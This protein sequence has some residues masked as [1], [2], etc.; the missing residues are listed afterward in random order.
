MSGCWDRDTTILKSVPEE[1]GLIITTPKLYELCKTL[2]QDNV[3]W[4]DIKK[5]DK[6]D[7]IIGLVNTIDTTLSG[8]NNL[9]SIV[10]GNNVAISL[11]K[12]GKNVI[13]PLL[14]LFADEVD[15][16]SFRDIINKLATSNGY[17]CCSATFDNSTIYGVED[18]KSKKL[19]LTFAY[20]KG[21]LMISTSKLTMETAIL[22]ANNGNSIVSTHAELRRLMQTQGKNAHGVV[23]VNYTKLAELLRQD[24]SQASAPSTINLIS[25][26]SEWG[27]LDINLSTQ[28]ITCAGYS[29]SKPGVSQYSKLMNMQQPVDNSFINMLPSKTASFTS[30]GIKDMDIFKDNYL[31]NNNDIGSGYHDLTNQMKSKYGIAMD[32]EIYNMIGDRITE[33]RCDYN[34]AGR[35]RDQ[36]IIASLRNSELAETVMRQLCTQYAKK[37]NIQENKAVFNITSSTN[38]SFTVYQVP[39][40]KLFSSYFSNIFTSAPQYYVCY[41]GWGVF[42]STVQSLKEYINCMEVRK[43]LAGNANFNEFA[44]LAASKSN[45]FYYADIAYC[46]AEIKALLNKANADSWAKNE[47]KIMNFRSVAFQMS[48]DDDGL[49]YTRVALMHSHIVEDERY[50]SWITPVDTTISRKPQIVKNHNTADKEV[51]V[52][53]NTNK[54]Y[55]FNKEGGRLFKKQMPEPVTSAVSQIDMYGNNK[56]Q[57]LFAT[58]NF[59][60]IIDRNGQY[61]SAFPLKL[62]ASTSAEISVFDYDKNSNYRIFVPCSDRKIY[63]YNQEGHILEGWPIKTREPVITPVQYFRIM[64]NDYLICA[65]NL[66]TY[67]LNR[68]G[69]VRINVTTNFSKGKNTLFYVD[70]SDG[71]DDPKFITTTASGEVVRISM[72][73]ACKISKVRKN[74]SAD[75]YFE[76]ADING[77]GNMEYIFSDQSLLEVYTLDGKLLFSQN[78][79]GTIGKPNLFA[80]SANDI[81]IGVTC[82]NKNKIY[83]INNQGN[84]CNGFP[85]NGISEF[86]I[87][88]LNNKDKYSVVTGSNENFLYNYLIK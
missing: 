27:V 20:T 76:F 16:K 11:I 25:R 52:F 55:L 15:F 54:M 44:N 10:S 24:L 50:I 77:D 36:Y 26:Q 51:V 28:N 66:K 59:L 43:T 85:L 30:M 86:S 35:S 69:E 74:Y 53:D 42:G 12:E 70:Y 49:T 39:V 87:T 37:Q 58:E 60:H 40:Q 88:K 48:N 34:L 4:G 5:I 75:H 7:N 62:P 3:M 72:N 22:H 2:N 33:F 80:F 38:K 61:V 31:T 47:N 32:V 57:Y 17:K 45:L 73:G 82:R 83:L 67:I 1:A 79:D 84:I 9:R 8:N 14:S 23:I 65:D 29:A 19:V 41:N 13:T 71:P 18:P 64:D 46:P 21:I 63:L 56:L 81:K 6:L 78:F 68:R